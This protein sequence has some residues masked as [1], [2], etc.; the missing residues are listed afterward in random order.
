[1]AIQQRLQAR[2]SQKLILTPSLQQAI[3]L[4]PMTTLELAELLNQEMIENPMLEEVQ[5]DD[6]VVETPSTDAEPEPV[7]AT[8]KGDTWD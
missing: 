3:K 1:M 8:E 6:Q 4:L 7:K 2:L 5:A